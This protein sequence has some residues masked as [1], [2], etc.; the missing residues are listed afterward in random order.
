MA[1]ATEFAPTTPKPGSLISA[2]ASQNIDMEENTKNGE[3]M[4]TGFDQSDMTRMGKIQELKVCCR[5][6]SNNQI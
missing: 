3:E 2:T 1:T 5:R 6:L 4:G